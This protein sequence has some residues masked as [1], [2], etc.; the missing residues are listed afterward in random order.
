MQSVHVNEVPENAQLIDVREPDEFADVHAAGAVNLPLSS[1][2][3][4][5]DKIDYDQPIYVICKAGGRS[6]EAAQYLEAVHGTEAINVLG[7]TQ[8]WVKA[9]LPTES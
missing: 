7:G 3:A 5:A 1:F 2:A 4:L 8:D 9:G 6:A